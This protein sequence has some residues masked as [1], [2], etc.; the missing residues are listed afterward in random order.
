MLLLISRQF[1]VMILEG[2]VRNLKN[3]FMVVV[4]LIRF[5]F[6]ENNL[7]INILKDTISVEIC[8]FLAALQRFK[9]GQ[10]PIHLL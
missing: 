7:R 1:A 10:N 2:F 6:H 5:I 3:S 8:L 9:V 4:A